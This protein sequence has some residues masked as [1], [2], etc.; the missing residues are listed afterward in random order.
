MELLYSF[1]YYLF[2]ILIVALYFE[3]IYISKYELNK[4]NFLILSLIIPFLILMQF[5][6][7][8]LQVPTL[9]SKQ[10]VIF[11]VI[12]VI[13]ALGISFGILFLI[14][15]TALPWIFS[16]T[17]LLIISLLASLGFFFTTPLFKTY[18]M[19]SLIMV[20]TLLRETIKRITINDLYS[21][22]GFLLLFGVSI[23]YFYR[24]TLIRTI[25]FPKHNVLLNNPVYLQKQ[26]TLGTTEHL[27]LKVNN[28]KNANSSLKIDHNYAYSFKFYLNPQGSNTRVAFNKDTLLINL[29]NNPT[30]FY[31]PQQTLLTLNFNTSINDGNTSVI[32]PLN[33]SKKGD[34]IFYQKWNS[35][36]LNVNDGSM[37]IFLNGVLIHTEKIIPFYTIQPINVGEQ[38]GL[39]G[40]IKDV[41]F[42][43]NPLSL[44]QIHML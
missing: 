20:V 43:E 26:T 1:I 34:L 4:H 29:G 14:G 40:G 18:V 9:N 32:I 27:N 12:G 7:D 30:V 21:M 35:V 10:S 19:P 15:K 23:T 11:K 17:T 38:R 5:A 33:D 22:L 16:K 28:D 25:A 13:L 2:V 42:Y 41:L 37:D 44:T 3:R 31:N 6:Y 36:T 39:E 24:T 8:V